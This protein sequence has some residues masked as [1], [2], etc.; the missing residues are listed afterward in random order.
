MQTSIKISSLVYAGVMIVF[1]IQHFMYSAFV[2]SLVPA[3]IPFHLFWAYFTGL[4]LI[5][6][7]LSIIMNKMTRAA[8]TLLGCMILFFII[9]IH[10]PIILDSK[11][12]AG[13]ITNCFKD[14]GLACGA[15]LIAGL[16]PGKENR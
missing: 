3:W 1:A 9:F 10:I 13:K 16:S 5:A 6:A 14:I 15:F 4:C 8:C 12:P 11:E 7:G 2:A